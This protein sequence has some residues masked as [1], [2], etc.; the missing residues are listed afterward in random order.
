M[1]DYS[2]S[3]TSRFTNFFDFITLEPNGQSAS[4]PRQVDGVIG[5]FRAGA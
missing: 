1:G 5:A 4:S 2:I 3:G